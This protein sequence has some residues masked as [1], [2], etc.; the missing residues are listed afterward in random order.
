LVPAIFVVYL[1]VAG[2]GRAALTAL[3]TFLG[4]VALGFAL[5]PVQSTAYWTRFVFDTGRVGSVAHVSNQSLF[6]LVARLTGGASV[7]HALW[8]AAALLVGTA[9]ILIAATLY[10]SGDAVTGALACACTGLL[11]SPVSW[12]HH[13]IWAAPI[14]V[15]LGHRTWQTRSG[16]CGLGLACWLAVFGS[17][18]IWYVPRSFGR[19]YRW[20]GWQLLAGNAYVLA[21]LAFLAALAARLVRDGRNWPMRLR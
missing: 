15:A 10:R 12:N 1:V 17:G 3:G 5:T 14:A 18:I 21:G 19:E 13:W 16:W 4:T 11:V 7:A 9:G 8:L 6:A 2:R 20:S